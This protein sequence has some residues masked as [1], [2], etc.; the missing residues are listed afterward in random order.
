M[1]SLLAIA[2][3]APGLSN[4]AAQ[5]TWQKPGATAQ[6]FQTDSYECERDVRQSGYYGTGLVGTINVNGFFNRCMEAR[7]YY[8]G[9]EDDSA[10]Q[11]M[12]EQ[13]ISAVQR[14]EAKGL[15][16]PSAAYTQCFDAEYRGPIEK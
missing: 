13:R 5:R 12:A 15:R 9:T 11:N 8:L 7:G 4:C 3:I 6:D 16:A 14:C 2:L 1:R 10:A